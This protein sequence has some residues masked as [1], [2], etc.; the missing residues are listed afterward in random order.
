MAIFVRFGVVVA[1]LN[2]TRLSKAVD[3]FVQLFS[4]NEVGTLG[5]QE[6]T[7]RQQGRHE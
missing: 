7:G 4:D 1:Y 6:T 5:G 2:I 3:R